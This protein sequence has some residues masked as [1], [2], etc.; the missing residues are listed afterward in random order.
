MLSDL[1]LPIRLDSKRKQIESR[2][3]SSLPYEQL[4]TLYRAQINGR[5]SFLCPSWLGN[6][7]PSPMVHDESPLRMDEMARKAAVTFN[8][9]DLVCFVKP[10][11]GTK[12][13]KFGQLPFR[14]R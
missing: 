6:I 11:H 2:M 14:Q 1:R 9:R 5:Q 12:S 7:L 8:A 3:L 10:A 13:V 4:L